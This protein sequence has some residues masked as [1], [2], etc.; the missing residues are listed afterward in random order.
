MNESLKN[1]IWNLS[2]F[3]LFDIFSVFN[4]FKIFN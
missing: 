2:W 4:Y 3:K 1:N